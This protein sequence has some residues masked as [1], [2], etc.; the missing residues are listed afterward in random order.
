MYSYMQTESDQN[1]GNTPESSLNASDLFIDLLNG[2]DQ[3]TLEFSDESWLS[4]DKER[5][6]VIPKGMQQLDSTKFRSKSN[7]PPPKER[8]KSHLDPRRVSMDHGN[9]FEFPFACQFCPKRFKR[10][11]PMCIHEKTH[12]GEKPYQCPL[13]MKKFFW[14]GSLSRHNRI[15][16]GEKPYKCFICRKRF[17]QSGTLNRHVR[18]HEGCSLDCRLCNQSFISVSD[19]NNHLSSHSEIKDESE[20]EERSR[21]PEFDEFKIPQYME[22]P[23]VTPII[24]VLSPTHF[25]SDLVLRP[26]L[27]ESKEERELMQIDMEK[28]TKAKQFRC[29][30]CDTSWNTQ[31]ALFDHYSIH[32]EEQA[33]SLSQQGPWD[34]GT[35]E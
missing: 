12:K 20:D 22:A 35:G 9:P 19:L 21:F 8:K 30:W 34:F 18:T 4:N 26:L 1:Y 14:S 11:K 3:D 25:S 27:E 5:E 15:H 32:L 13:C 10:K 7:S 16:T 6:T 24:P 31:M 29:T 17:T 2:R 28:H 23:D 33:V